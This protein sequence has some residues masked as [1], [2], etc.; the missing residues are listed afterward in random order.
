MYNGS[1]P[2][3]LVATVFL[4][5][6]FYSASPIRKSVL[7]IMGVQ[8]LLISLSKTFI[9]SMCIIAFLLALKY[10]KVFFKIRNIIIGLLIVVS[11][12]SVF[13]EMG[14]LRK[15]IIIYDTVV[16]LREQTTFIERVDNHWFVNW[17]EHLMS[18]DSVF[19]HGV[20]NIGFSYDSLYFYSFYVF[21]ILGC[22]GLILSL[23][24]LMLNGST[25]F[26]Y[27]ILILLT[28]GLFLETALISY[29]GL[30]PF[31][32]FLSYYTINNITFTRNKVSY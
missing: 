25:V 31:I 14:Y 27:Y 1:G 30:E 32:L 3:G 12:I 20:T 18:Q 29:R 7:I 17:D 5:I 23:V 9:F 22:A 21:G 6:G 2:L 24:V 10:Y 4:F 13:L 26:K 16:N 19:G 11:V 8:L 15:F 28:S